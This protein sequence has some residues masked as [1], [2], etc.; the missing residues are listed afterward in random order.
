LSDREQ[1]RW[2]CH[3]CQRE[4][5]NPEPSGSGLSVGVGVIDSSAPNGLRPWDPEQDGCR[6]CSSKNIELVKYRPEF[7]G[8]DAP[9]DGATAAA[10]AP[11]QPVVV[12]PPLSLL[13]TPIESEPPSLDT[14]QLI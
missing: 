3:D 10:P 2:V 11:P 13:G 7:A 4:F 6:G 5:I 12:E 14:W 8:A 1:A 9:R